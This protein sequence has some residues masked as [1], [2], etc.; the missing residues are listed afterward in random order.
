MDIIRIITCHTC[1]LL[2]TIHGLE[3]VLRDD[4]AFRER[5]LHVRVRQ[6]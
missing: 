2:L 6:N 5:G 1:L 3:E 4:D